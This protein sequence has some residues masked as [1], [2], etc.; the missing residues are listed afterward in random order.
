MRLALLRAATEFVRRLTIGKRFGRRVQFEPR[1]KRERAFIAVDVDV[2]C[3]QVAGHSI[4][5]T[6]EQC[7][8]RN[9]L[10]NLITRLLLAQQVRDAARMTQRAGEMAFE[11][12][13]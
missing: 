3:P 9:R 8:G 1:T 4:E 11:N 10:G 2:V 6:G 13:R 5:G 12:L 7:V